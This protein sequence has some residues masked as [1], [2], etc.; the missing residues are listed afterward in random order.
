VVLYG[1]TMK[2]GRPGNRIEVL[3]QPADAD[4]LEGVLLATT[5]TIGVRR[6]GVERRVLPRRAR[7]VSVLGHRVAIKA[8]TLPDGTV[9]A[10]PEFEDVRRAAEA[11]GRSSGDI[12]ALA[13]EA[14]RMEQYLPE[15]R[16][17]SPSGA[18]DLV[19]LSPS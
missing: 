17:A 12:F 16:P 3:A 13:V 11:T 14:A 2:K 4:R 18:P 8:S 19:T 9:R 6:W 15:S 7:A 1:T 5:T 10:K